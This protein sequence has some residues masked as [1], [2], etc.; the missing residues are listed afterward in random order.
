MITLTH[1]QDKKQKNEKFACLTCY[2]ASF[3]NLMNRANIEVILV[4]DSLGMVVQG[5]PSTL[6]VSVADMAYHTQNVARANDHALIMADLPFMS[7]AR[8]ED[9]VANARILMQAGANVVKL[10][11]GANL[12]PI[13]EVLTQAGAPCCVHLGLTPQSV[14]LFGGYKVQGKTTDHAQK[15]LAD[16]QAVV[17]AGAA[18]LVLECV[19]AH[20]GGAITQAVD[21]PVIGIG[22]GKQTDGQI[23]V[24]QDM[25]GM[26]IG[27]QPRFIHDFLSDPHNEDHSILGAFLHYRQAVI[28]G[29]FPNRSHEFA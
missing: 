4:G 5:K 7:Y 23:L 16:A 1:L 18:L 24:M 10:E 19:P 14:N 2:E 25:L 29:K 11:G 27:K 3:A 15:L 22:A 12:V 9:A 6:G 26:T 20:L 28:T 8:L 17:Q 21:V 13:I